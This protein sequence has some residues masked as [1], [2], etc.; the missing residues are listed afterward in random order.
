[1]DAASQQQVDAF[2]AYGVNFAAG[3]FV[4]GTGV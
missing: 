4:A 1:V 2:F 3:L